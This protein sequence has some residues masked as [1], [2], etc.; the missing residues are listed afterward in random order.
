MK[1]DVQAALREYGDRAA[2]WSEDSFNK[3]LSVVVEEN[4]DLSEAA[5]E[6]GRKK[7]LEDVA[8]FA[9]QPAAGF[10][11]SWSDDSVV[12]API[13]GSGSAKDDAESVFAELTAGKK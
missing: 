11:D 3:E 6:S 9:N 7:L 2:E 5:K 4:E 13:L 10:D 12:V 1:V 8:D